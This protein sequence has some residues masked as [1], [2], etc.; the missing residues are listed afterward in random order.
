MGILILALP[1]SQQV[2]ASRPSETISSLTLARTLVLY[3]EKDLT[4][5]PES[6]LLYRGGFRS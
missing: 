6:A 3:G 1:H 4:I 5:L 2:M